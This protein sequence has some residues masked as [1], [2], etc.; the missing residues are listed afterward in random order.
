[1]SHLH[2]KCGHV[3]KAILR[4]KLRT[5]DECG[6]GISLSTTFQP[7]T[8]GNR[9]VVDNEMPLPSTQAEFEHLYTA[10]YT[11]SVEGVTARGDK[12]FTPQI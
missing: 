2:N 10:S 11:M 3:I 8:T 7:K 4:G 12:D 1:M 9:D 5:A 6:N